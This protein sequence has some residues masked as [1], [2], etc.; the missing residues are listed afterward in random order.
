MHCETD[1]IKTDLYALFKLKK[2]NSFEEGVSE[3]FLF[4]HLFCFFPIHGNF[5]LVGSGKKSIWNITYLSE[6]S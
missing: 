5:L 2:K 1:S 4:S 3:V 6:H